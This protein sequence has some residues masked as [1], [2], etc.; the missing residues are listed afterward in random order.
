LPFADSDQ[1]A[2]H[3]LYAVYGQL[4]DAGD[5][6]GWVALF[7]PD[8]VYTIQPRT[9]SERWPEPVVLEGHDGVRS[10][11]ERGIEQY[12]GKVRHYMT[13]YVFDGDG[14]TARG[15]GYGMTVDLRS[16]SPV[17]MA[18]GVTDDVIVKVDG[19][20]CF[21]SRILTPDA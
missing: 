13:N 14:D 4:F 11:I 15:S 5:V 6:E 17:I 21:K 3:R 1:L 8:V 7:T 2:L 18:T 19:R 10:W 9:P 16:G 12:H 20:W